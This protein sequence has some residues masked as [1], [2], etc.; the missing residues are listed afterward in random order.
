MRIRVK[1]ADGGENTYNINPHNLKL[2]KSLY[3]DRFLGVIDEP[4]NKNSL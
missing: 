1:C 3:G 2:L 4:A